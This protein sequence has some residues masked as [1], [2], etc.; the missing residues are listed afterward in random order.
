MLADLGF[1]FLKGNW[2]GGGFSCS[3]LL[4]KSHYYFSSIQFEYIIVKILDSTS[5]FKERLN[6]NIKI[7]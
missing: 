2:G 7:I 4:L 6:K 3:F 5:K 1:S